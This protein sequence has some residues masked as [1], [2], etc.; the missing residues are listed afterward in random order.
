[1]KT[2]AHMPSHFR[3]TRH[4]LTSRQRMSFCSPWPARHMQ[5]DQV[6]MSICP[7]GND[8][9]MAQ[10]DPTEAGLLINAV[11]GRQSLIA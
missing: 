4:G 10:A 8:V 11:A 7:L 6:I 1:M 9:D 2:S 3:E 5:S